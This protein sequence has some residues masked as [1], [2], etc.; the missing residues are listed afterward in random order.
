VPADVAGAMVYLSSTH[1]DFVTGQMIAV[2]GWSE[3]L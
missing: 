1:S 3:T 2:N